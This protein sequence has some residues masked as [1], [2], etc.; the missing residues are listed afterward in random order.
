MAGVN[1]GLGLIDQLS[2]RRVFRIQRG[3]L[4]LEPLEVASDL[5]ERLGQLV[6][7][8]V[9]VLADDLQ[10]RLGRVLGDA[11]RL[12]DKHETFQYRFFTSLQRR[13]DQLLQFFRRHAKVANHGVVA[14]TSAGRDRARTR[15]DLVCKSKCGLRNGDRQSGGKRGGQKWRS[16]RHGLAAGAAGAMPQLTVLLVAVP[17]VAMLQSPLLTL[18]PNCIPATSHA[19]IPRAPIPNA[20]IAMR[21]SA[22]ARL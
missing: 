15:L 13:L 5:G 8:N 7:G 21:R 3:G 22:R 4:R 10:K 2:R 18:V 9:R 17:F 16:G 12:A 1:L 14:G 20:P 11:E 6:V 19:T